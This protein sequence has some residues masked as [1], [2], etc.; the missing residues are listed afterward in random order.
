[1]KIVV[2][3]SGKGGT[4]KT[5]TSTLVATHL[6]KYFKVGLLDTDLS[7]PKVGEMFGLY[8]HRYTFSSAGKLEPVRWKGIGEDQF[9]EVFSLG[10][11]IPPDQFV[12]WKGS[13]ISDMIKEQFTSIDW[14][15]IDVL[16]VDLPPSTSDSVQTVLEMCGSATVV[17]ITINTSLAISD[18]RRFLSLVRSKKM[19]PTDMLLNMSDLYDNHTDEEIEEI[20]GVKILA[21]I[22][23]NKDFNAP[24]AGLKMMANPDNQ[25]A[26]TLRGIIP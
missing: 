12:A 16:V 8:K 19:I 20:L 5:T 4:G 3:G 14:G 2:V 24:E 1:M 23:F 13:Q 11:D 10:A 15:D 17:P 6:T 7:S 18:T 9:L 22:P 26:D 21:H 25:L